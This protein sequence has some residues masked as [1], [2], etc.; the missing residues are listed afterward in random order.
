MDQS[1]VY[2]KTY[3]AHR[4]FS[5]EFRISPFHRLWIE[6]R[7]SNE[8]VPEAALLKLRLTP[9]PPPPGEGL[10]VRKDKSVQERKGG[11][12]VTRDAKANG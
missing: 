6:E 3:R 5:S 10:S 8:R 2:R 1:E 9:S 7:S 11:S 4:A 12:L